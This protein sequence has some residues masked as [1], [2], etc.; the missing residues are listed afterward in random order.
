[1][2]FI[3]NPDICLIQGVLFLV[4][5]GRWL[6]LNLVDQNTVLAEHLTWLVS[7]AVCDSRRCFLWVLL[8]LLRRDGSQSESFQ[9][10][11]WQWHISA[12]G[13]RKATKEAGDLNKVWYSIYRTLTFGANTFC[14][15]DVIISTFGFVQIQFVCIFVFSHLQ[16]R[17]R[18][19]GLKVAE[20]TTYTTRVNAKKASMIH[21]TDS[22][23]GGE[24]S[25]EDELKALAVKDDPQFTLAVTRGY[26]AWNNAWH[27]TRIMLWIWP[28][29]PIR[30][31]IISFPLFIYI[32]LILDRQ[33]EKESLADYINKKRE[34]FLV[35]VSM[36]QP[37]HS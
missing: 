30:T 10:A 24:L 28:H 27:C 6:S 32:S 26:S 9:N 25:D 4:S 14:T 16:E 37:L 35:Q 5:L 21:P 22:D 8:C 34:M 17:I 18:Q 12:E 31:F 20:K 23:E 36:M 29:I 13:Q 2:C 3:C 1:M 11:W 33:V 19:R 7:R 15:C